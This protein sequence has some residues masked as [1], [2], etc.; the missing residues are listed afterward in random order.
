[1]KK[2]LV[3]ILA[4][5]CF[6]HLSKPRLTSAIEF[7]TAE[8]N[9]NRFMAIAAPFGNSPQ[10]YRLVIVE[11]LY[12]SYACWIQNSANPERIK[13]LPQQSN[14]DGICEIRDS[15]NDYSIRLEGQDL[16]PEYEIEIIKDDGDLVLVGKSN[17]GSV[18]IPIEI[19]RTKGIDKG[20]QRII[21]NPGW[22][23]TRRIFNGRDLGHIY[24]TGDLTAIETPIPYIAAIAPQPEA[25]ITNAAPPVVGV[26]IPSPL[27]NLEEDP[28]S[29]TPLSSPITTNS[30][31]AVTPTPEQENPSPPS[32]DLI[33]T[34]PEVGIIPPT[35]NNNN[36]SPEFIPTAPP[37]STN[38]L[39]P[40][41]PNL[42]Q[43][44][45]GVESNNG[46]SLRPLKLPNLGQSPPPTNLQPSPNPQPR[47]LIFTAPEGETFDPPEDNSSP[48]SIPKTVPT[49]D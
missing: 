4:S 20:F 37:I 23:F 31:P 36:S 18:T 39:Q 47:D 29:N 10:N 7:S 15:S 38:S 46:F 3:V 24:L 21:L 1:M 43:I 30:L 42:E 9:P 19:G 25:E 49:L 5:T 44:N 33:F 45:L 16:A 11:Q 35:I 2:F 41:I 32:Q 28:P 13:P 40:K 17:Q 27:P 26:K 8:V 34:T 48:S 12:D 6:L 22:R 14:Y